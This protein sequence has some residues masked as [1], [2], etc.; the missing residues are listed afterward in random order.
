MQSQFILM[1]ENLA[2]KIYNESKPNQTNRNETQRIKLKRNESR[3]TLHLYE[4]AHYKSSKLN[5]KFVD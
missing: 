5:V 1:H 3:R 4:M 2:D